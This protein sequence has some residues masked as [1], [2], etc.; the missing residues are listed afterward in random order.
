MTWVRL[1]DGAPLHP[2][3][4][5]VG[6]EAAWLWVAGLAYANRHVTN[7]AIPPQALPALYPSD[8]WP[9]ARLA[10][11]AAALVE[12]GLWTAREGGGWEVHDYAQYQAEAMRDAVDERRAWERE[13]KAKQRAAQKPREHGAPAPSDSRG[14]PPMSHRDRGGT[15]P[16][17]KG[18]TEGGTPARDT[19][20]TS[21]GDTHA[22]GGG[23]SQVVSQAPG[24]TR[25]VPEDVSLSPA[26][27]S[28]RTHEHTG[29][30]VEELVAALRERS[31][32]AILVLGG[33]DALVS[34]ALQ[35]ALTDLAVSGDVTRADLDTLADW[36]GAGSQAWRA[37]RLGLRELA[38]KGG[39]LA[40]H[41][42]AARAWDRAGRPDPRA[43]PSAP[44]RPPG[45][46]ARP[47]S[48]PARPARLRPAPCSRPE[49]FADD[50]N[51][52]TDPL[53]GM[54]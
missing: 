48:A 22:A 28:V 47:G 20:G 53:L 25:P 39:T 13:R 26:G 54:L 30:R 4:L 11:L 12:A 50:N 14:L 29:L 40:E 7:G 44:S 10:K 34:V 18:G 33:G 46:H 27:A 16:W 35:R 8:Q 23:L 49:D 32:G 45:A 24:P 51:P 41:I 42:E 1:D 17:D 52:A 6:P 21:V 3:L 5:A 36:Y 37:S 38:T 15:V 43:T 31:K 2:K 19:G 9:R